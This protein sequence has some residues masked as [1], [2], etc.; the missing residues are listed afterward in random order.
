MLSLHSIEDTH[1]IAKGGMG[2]D[3]WMEL[4]FVTREGLTR[5]TL[6]FNDNSNMFRK[7]ER[8]LELLTAERADFNSPFY[9]DPPE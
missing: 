8:L 5:V 4:E 6:Y 9:V 1:L 7:L 2:H 3:R